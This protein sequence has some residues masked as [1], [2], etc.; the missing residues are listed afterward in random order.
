MSGI[1]EHLRTLSTAEDF[2]TVLEVP[3]EQGVL[4]VSRL[5]ILKRFQQ[6]LRQD[7]VDALAEDARK[8]ACA[9]CLKRAHDDFTTSSG[10][11]AKMF[12]VFQ[13]QQQPA[14]AFVSLS[15]LKTGRG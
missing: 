3:F 10:V 15:T 7:G 12:K 14:P 9:A 2:F 1:L 6:Y 4:N 8:A 13:D 11:D 5:H